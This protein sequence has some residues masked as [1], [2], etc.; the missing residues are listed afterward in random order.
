[1]GIIDVVIVLLFIALM[2]IGFLRGFLKQVLS[3]LSWVIALVAASLLCKAI[4]NVLFET[5]IGNNLNLTINYWIASKGEIFST[6]LPELTSEY[7]VEVLNNLRIPTFVHESLIGMID[8]SGFKNM[9][10][11]EFISPKIT[12]LLLTIVSYIVVFL[13][14][15]ITL[16]V[17]AIIFSKIVKSSALSLLDGILG[18]VWGAIQATIIVSLVMLGLS[19]IITLPSCE[20]I[21]E[22][23]TQDLVIAKSGLRVAKFFFDNN[24]LLF[25][26][27][28]LSLNK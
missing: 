19:F 22:W 5:G 21:N 17:L 2:V 7:L 16:K 4:G 1:M 6:P 20:Q 27:N 11:A 26:F 24:P 3:S 28:E 25:V 13:I 8:F 9:T 18:L 14:V 23:V 15:F 10:I 12:I